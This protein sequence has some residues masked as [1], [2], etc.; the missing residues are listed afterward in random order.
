VPYSAAELE[1][2]GLCVAVEA[3]NDIANHALLD[4][5]RNVEPGAEIAVRYKSRD[6]QHLFLIRLLDFAKEGGDENLTGVRGSCLNVLLAACQSRSFDVN[7][8]IRGLEQATT[9]LH[10]WLHAET[11]FQMW[12]PTLDLNAQL[13]VPRIEFLYILG[14]HAKHNLARLTRIARRIAEL[15]DRNG[16]V[17]DLEQVPLA[18]DDFREHL[19][20]DYFAYYGTWLAELVN[21]VRWGI[22]DYLLP[23]YQQA[24]VR[25]EDVLY[26]YRYPD[27][28]TH[29]TPRAWFWRLMNQV[30]AAPY[31]GRFTGASY[32]KQELL[33]VHR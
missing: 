10:R 20:E 16:H 30:R 13:T 12:L 14:N 8:S 29:E 23:A 24:Y 19:Q 7:G 25:G 28:I 2:I 22:Q 11:T 5:P 15:L 3:I 18:L 6:H 1:A 17:V 26:S 4:V 33:R 9:A 21:N 32:M 27:A 31:I